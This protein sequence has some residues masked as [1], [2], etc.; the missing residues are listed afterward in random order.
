MA[1]AGGAILPLAFGKVAQITGDMQSAYLVGIVCYF[2]IFMYGVKW[3]KK[4]SW[5]SN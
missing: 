1:I 5:G 2:F 3:H 4:S